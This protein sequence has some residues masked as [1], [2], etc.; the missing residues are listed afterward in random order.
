MP[1]AV[2]AI[3]AAASLSGCVRYRPRPLDPA[4]AAE[5]FGSR[6]L[7]D[8]GV[9]AFA[10]T[11]L[12]TRLDPWPPASWD[13]TTLTLAAFYYHPSLD[14]A[15][16]RWE[17]AKAQ[18]ITAGQRRNPDLN[19]TPGYNTSL[20]TPSPWLPLA[21]L[22]IPLE[23]AGKRGHRIARAERLSEAA[24]LDIASTAWQVRSGVRAALT[25]FDTARE[26]LKILEER[27]ALDAENVKL[28][29]GQ[30]EAGAIS[31]FELTQARIAADETAFALGEAR[32]R[33][34]EARVRLASAIGVPASALEGMEF[35]A[36]DL[37]RAPAEETLAGARRQAL[38]NRSD[39]LGAL[40]EYAASE[41][42]LQLEIARQYPD[43]RLLPGYQYDQGEDKWTLGLT[44]TLP[45]LNRN[46]GGIA[47]AEAARNEAAAKFDLLQASVVA[48]IDG[49]LAAVHA[50]VKTRADAEALLARLQEQ[51][52]RARGVFETGEISRSELVAL[53][54][55]I[56]AS[57]LARL[58]ALARAREA[59]GQLEDALQSPLGLP[60]EAWQ[61]PPRPPEKEGAKEH[62]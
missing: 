7:D 54:L 22:D 58:D 24:R 29:E 42:A 21:F 31:A 47:E 10:E 17:M 1:A 52:K 27:Q 59:L 37:D 23:T 12:N 41:S 2:A 30:Y 56:E 32:R 8:P 43:I 45:I 62:P 11:N 13:L 39:S 50:A 16:A 48:S 14:L 4:A 38:M 3:F 55:Q 26:G 19:V 20:S 18:G 33:N 44:V 51:E 9:K 25:A 28:L 61:I 60:P 49:A 53:R 34:D 35:T 46:K 15:R 36:A 6:R 5:A 57:A 40:A